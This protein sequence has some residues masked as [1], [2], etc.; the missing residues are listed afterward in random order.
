MKSSIDLSFPEIRRFNVH[1][2]SRNAEIPYRS[3]SGLEIG[4]SSP[5]AQQFNSYAGHG[6]QMN[7]AV[8]EQSM[9]TRSARVQQPGQQATQP[10]QF[11]GSLQGA[12]NAAGAAGADRYGPGPG[13]SVS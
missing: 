13:R 1:G 6:S 3:A 12:T 5:I 7:N 8:F 4:S 10:G 9:S 2:E 11:Y